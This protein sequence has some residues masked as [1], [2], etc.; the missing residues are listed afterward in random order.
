MLDVSAALEI[1]L[2]FARPPAPTSE[3]LGFFALGETIAEDLAA[4]IDSPPFTKA[5]MD[6]YALRTVDLVDGR[7]KLRS[8]ANSRR[9]RVRRCQCTPAK[10]SAFS[11]GR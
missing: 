4:D 7:A 1:V 5:L 10:R 3:G 9:G 11:P 2:Q 8:W 6:G